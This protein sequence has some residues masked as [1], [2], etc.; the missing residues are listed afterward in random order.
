M[1]KDFDKAVDLLMCLDVTKLSEL[2]DKHPFLVRA[3]DESGYTLLTHACNTGNSN[4]V[5]CLI[6][7]D[8]DVNHSDAS[9]NTP[10]IKASAKGNLQVASM[11]IER[12]ANIDA[13][14]EEGETALS[15]AVVYMNH[16][17][18]SYLIEHGASVN[19]KTSYG[20]T[21]LTLAVQS[22]CVPTIESLIEN[23][24][25]VNYRT[26]TSGVLKLAIASGS[27]R[28]IR[29]IAESD[30]YVKVEAEEKADLYIELQKSIDNISKL[31]QQL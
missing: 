1:T 5:D 14:N 20:E 3:C 19:S 7:R 23:G 16:Q 15:Y 10:L 28:I 27:K 17:L 2:L 13:S 24:A 18:V 22:L 29:L 6:C 12:G 30:S 21:P 4:A 31:V 8:S 11:L 25:D 9:G 26:E